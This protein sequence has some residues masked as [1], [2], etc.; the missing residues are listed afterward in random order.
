MSCFIDGWTWGWRLPLP[1]LCSL[2]YYR[3]RCPCLP[4]FIIRPTAYRHH[5]NKQLYTHTDTQ[6]KLNQDGRGI[7]GS[8]IAWKFCWACGSLNV[9]APEYI[10]ASRLATSCRFWNVSNVIFLLVPL[11]IHPVP[12]FNLLRN[13]PLIYS[14]NVGK[15]NEYMV[16]MK[17]TNEN[18]IHQINVHDHETSSLGWSCTGIMHGIPL[19]STKHILLA[20]ESFW[21]PLGKECKVRQHLKIPHKL[22]HFVVIWTHISVVC[23]YLPRLCQFERT[24]PC[25]CGLCEGSVS[26]EPL[27]RSSPSVLPS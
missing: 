24:C 22:R 9:C 3:N 16:K 7:L 4:P 25:P 5:P 15:P 26:A 27:Q 20:E 13:Q 21:G 11:F 10:F 14:V 17:R 18:Q 1:L 23:P 19:R 2:C 12:L 8:F 6:H